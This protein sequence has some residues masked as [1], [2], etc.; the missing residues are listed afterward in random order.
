VRQPAGLR[1]TT[2]Q[3]PAREA[4]RFA[5]DSA[6][7]LAP[8]QHGERPGC[9]DRHGAVNESAHGST[10]ISSKSATKRMLSTTANSPLIRHTRIQEANLGLQINSAF[11]RSGS[12]V[13]CRV[14]LG[15]LHDMQN[16]SLAKPVALD[17]ASPRSSTMGAA[18]GTSLTSVGALAR[19]VI[20][21]SPGA[22]ARLQKRISRTAIGVR[23]VVTWRL[24]AALGEYK[25]ALP[26]GAGPT[27]GPQGR[28]FD[29]LR[30]HQF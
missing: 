23:R 14:G 17:W 19:F 5:A 9:R 18:V 10:L 29:S 28:G 4:E 21:V 16:R 8:R 3:A 6:A 27:S 20:K 12:W 25:I 15:Y 30:A 11:L 1:V 13:P 26:N 24:A 22:T 7:V 2:W